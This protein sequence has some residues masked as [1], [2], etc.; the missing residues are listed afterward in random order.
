MQVTTEERRRAV[1]HGRHLGSAT[2]PLLLLLAATY[3]GLSIAVWQLASPD[4]TGAPWWPAAG[5]TLAV[6]CRTRRADWPALA[7]TIFAADLAADLVEGTQVA[8]SLVWASSNT[9][10]PLLGAWA[11]GLVFAG[12]LPNLESPRNVAAFF[13]TAALAGAP[14]ASLL[15]S[16]ASTLTYDLDFVAT[17]RTWYIGDVLG[18]LVVAPVVLYSRQLRAAFDARLGALLLASGVVALLVFSGSGGSLLLPYLVLPLLVVTALYYGAPG[19]AAAGLITAVIADILSALGHGPFAFTPDS[20][21]ALVGLQL[22]TAVELLTVYMLVGLR[23]QLLS[24]QARAARL[25]KEKLIDPL[26]GTG[27]RFALDEALVTVTTE[28]PVG[29]SSEPAAAL[30]LDLDGFKPINDEHGHEVGDEVLVEVARRIERAVRA[31]DTVA[32]IGGDEFAIVCPGAD[33]TV[34]KALVRRLEEAI[35]TPM[36]VCGLDLTVSASIGYAW[37]PAPTGDPAALIRR[38]DLSMYESKSKRDGERTA[39]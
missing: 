33:E 9:I 11:L 7:L 3:F 39:S 12:R 35:H 15:G 18:I 1:N 29:V 32:R 8:T 25:S 36:N 21:N 23:A 5:L 20:E 26:T 38:A 24:A 14:L 17:W 34:A 16:A 31:E 27:N 10:E 6:M 30:F 4:V 2:P 19:A 13:L 22:F 37:I 28:P